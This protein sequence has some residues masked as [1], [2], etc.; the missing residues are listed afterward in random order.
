MEKIKSSLSSWVKTH[1]LNLAI[2]NLILMILVLLHTAKY[3][4]PF[5]L[6]SI[7]AIIFFALVLSIFILNIKSTILFIISLCF[8]L[9]ASI[10]KIAKIDIWAERTTVYVYQ[11]FFLGIISLFWEIAKQKLKSKS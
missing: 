5:W 6:I 10:M 8:F 1:Y 7:N 2:Y 3:F 11:S 4:D 9:F